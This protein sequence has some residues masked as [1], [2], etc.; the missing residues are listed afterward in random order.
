M[1]AVHWIEL[2][3]L[4][5]PPRLRTVLCQ[6]VNLVS[7]AALSCSKL[8]FWCMKWSPLTFHFFKFP[9]SYLNTTANECILC[10]KGTYQDQ[11]L[12]TSCIQCPQDTTTG[13]GATKIEDCLNPC[14]VDGGET[15]CDHNAY[16]VL[17]QE[18]NSHKCECKVGYNGTG[19]GVGSCRGKIPYIF[20]I[21]GPDLY[22][23][24]KLISTIISPSRSLH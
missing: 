14:N 12:Q 16:C 10:G 20:S 23:N 13:I 22:K 3:K 5:V 18:T 19:Y 6:S 8:F 11:S 4:P 24:L 1:S 2:L 7:F 21:T 15:L 9:G 17:N